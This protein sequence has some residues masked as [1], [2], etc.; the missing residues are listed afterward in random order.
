MLAPANFAMPSI[1]NTCKLRIH[2]LNSQFESPS[3]SGIEW[4]SQF[5]PELRILSH[6][7]GTASQARR[8]PL[9]DIPFVVQLL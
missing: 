2:Q 7:V 9:V 4:I 6:G 8:L 5:A 1:K 3:G